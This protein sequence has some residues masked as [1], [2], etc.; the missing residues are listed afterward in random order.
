MNARSKYRISAAILFILALVC[1]GI[2][3]RTA[4][5]YKQYKAE[6]FDNMKQTAREQTQATATDLDELIQ[7]TF[8]YGQQTAQ[9]LSQET[10]TPT[11]I[12]E[13]LQNKPVEITGLGVLLNNAIAYYTEKDGKQQF[14]THKL[15]SQTQ[16]IEEKSLESEIGVKFAH[17][18]RLASQQSQPLLITDPETNMRE[19]I[20]A[21]PFKTKD[22]SEGI[23]FSTLAVA[24]LNHLLSTLSL[25]RHGYWSITDKNN[26]F[27]SHPHK[28]LVKKSVNI[29]NILNKQ[30]IQLS[31]DATFLEYHN[32]ITQA[33]SWLF[34]ANIPSAQMRLGG[35]FDPR[36]VIAEADATQIRK[37]L[38]L[39]TF[40]IILGLVLLILSI[41]LWIISYGL[42]RRHKNITMWVGSSL[43]AILFF[44]GVGTF[45]HIRNNDPTYEK[46][47]T[48]IHNKGE[49]YNFLDAYQREKSNLPAKM[50]ESHADKLYRLALY[51]YKEGRYVPT[52]ILV[53]DIE[54]KDTDK[55]DFV[56][57]IWQR[58]F[59]GIHDDI[60]RG[61]VLPQMTTVSSLAPTHVKEISRIKEGKVETIVWEVHATLNQRL[62]YRL[63]P[64]DTKNLQIRMQHRDFEKDIILVPDLD[65]YP[66]I[67]PLTLPGIG[68]HVHPSNWEIIRSFFGYEK[69]PYNTNF[70]LY[71]Y[72]PFG[73]Y[74]TIEKSNIPELSFVITA[75]RSLL[76]T[77]MNHVFLIF[78]I[79]IILFVLLVTHTLQ[80]FGW[81]IGTCATIFFSTILAQMRFRET[82]PSNEF[83]YLESFYFILYIVTV[84][85]LFTSLFTMARKDP[86]ELGP[87]QYPIIKVV[88]WPIISGMLFFITFWYLF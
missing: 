72:G 5:I 81:T 84:A 44:G 20:F 13:I 28:E 67:A 54:F 86:T 47:I 52:G 8:A 26:V 4:F 87:D 40:F 34:F 51:R 11:S 3:T 33:P 7:K 16:P 2:A 12:Q 48:S 46:E 31:D 59:D 25:G 49:L 65:A 88:Y 27:I 37:N 69:M 45:W 50:D 39:M 53:S 76:D 62:N 63:Y 79:F 22:S 6:I 18:I 24:H 14:L 42:A 41:T 17:I 10:L 73:V 70:G 1:F 19:L 61:F 15:L 56:G 64:F 82:F 38:I 77:I 29:N 35:V 60:S 80:G 21:I 43:I 83:V 32:E 57:Y 66:R 78:V 85:L 9:A 36:E 55:L 58:Y 71:S 74:K 68:P 30:N 23:V 75:K